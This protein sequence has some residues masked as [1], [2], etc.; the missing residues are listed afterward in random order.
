MWKGTV[1]VSDFSSFT[2]LANLSF[3]YSLLVIQVLLHDIVVSIRERGRTN[4]LTQIA[5]RPSRGIICSYYK[6]GHVTNP[7]SRRT[8][9]TRHQN[10][11]TGTISEAAAATAAALA[12]RPT[13]PKPGRPPR[14][15]S[16]RPLG[17]PP[18]DSQPSSAHS[19][20]SPSQRTASLSPSAELPPPFSTHRQAAEYSM[21]RGNSN[22]NVTSHPA[23]LMGEM[24]PL[25][26]RPTPTTTPTIPSVM[27]PGM[28]RQPPTSN[29]NYMTP[30]PPI[31]E[32]HTKPEYQ[33]Q[34]SPHLSGLGSPHMSS[35]GS[36]HISHASHPYSPAGYR[37]PS[38]P[39]SAV[40]S[41]EQI[42]FPPHPPAS[43]QS[44][45][46]SHYG[47]AHLRRAHSSENMGSYDMHERRLP[48]M[49]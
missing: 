40:S 4:V 46:Q 30:L 39:T 47:D 14:S 3:Q 23:S 6:L 15:P 16:A 7:L 24:Q 36:P 11:H 18:N 31:L 44:T 41:D 33:R 45:S 34:S 8:T 22:M 21:Y 20:P 38:Y 37:S 29:P 12:A 35:A 5:K 49:F 26:P 43:F 32:P 42:F 19:T 17:R 25:T 10:H 2:R 13:L 9:L 28:N 48:T 27:V 1:S